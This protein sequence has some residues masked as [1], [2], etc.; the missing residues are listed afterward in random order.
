MFSSP[1]TVLLQI[2]IWNKSRLLPSTYFLIPHTSTDT[3][4]FLQEQPPDEL[5]ALNLVPLLEVLYFDRRG[6]KK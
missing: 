3:S 1:A 2:I 6:G 4:S 5:F